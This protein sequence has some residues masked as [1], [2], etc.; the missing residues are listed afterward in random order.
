MNLA[1]A[2]H[3]FVLGPTVEY[4][5]GVHKNIGA[6]AKGLGSTKA[7]IVTDPNLVK[8]GVVEKVAAP[9]RA[10][11]LQVEVFEKVVSEPTDLFVHEGAEF[12]KKTGADLVIGLGGG[13]AMDCAKCI[14]VMAENEGHLTQYEGAAAEFPNDKKAALIT[15]PT[16]SGSGAE[17]AGWSV[18]TDSARSYK[19]SFGSPYLEP[20]YVFVDPELTLELPRK[21]TVYSGMDALSQAIEG[22]LSV[23]R[24]PISVALGLYAVK[25]LSENLPKVYSHGWDL[26]A[27]SNMSIGSFLAGIVINTS[28]CISVHALAET[29]GGLYHQPHGLLVGLC[30]PHVLEFL[31]PGDHE[32][33]AQVATALG[34]N[35]AGLSTFEAA[36]LAIVRVNQILDECDF[37]F[38]TQVGLK[39]DDIPQIAQLAMGNVCTSDNPC[40]M[41]E[42]DYVAILN[43]A[44][45]DNRPLN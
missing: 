6:V 34:A 17:I 44:L 31:L 32:L 18:I 4:G 28:G 20:G 45:A 5:P 35:T 24:T 33:L 42:A 12:L 27:R 23:R 2:K 40:T 21:P 8:S 10:E 11:G 29:M 14:A 15:L 39:A 22:M 13:S 37:P 26:E 7:L 1:Y 36:K 38:L 41:T 3:M 16:T 25:L 9:L 43:S 30:L 19:M